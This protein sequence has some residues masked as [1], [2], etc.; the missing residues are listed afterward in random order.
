MEQKKFALILKSPIHDT[1]I[2][3]MASWRLTPSKI[4][5]KALAAIVGFS[6]SPPAPDP[7]RQ[8]FLTAI[9]KQFGRMTEILYKKQEGD[10]AGSRA[11]K[12]V[13][14]ISSSELLL[15]GLETLLALPV[16]ERKHFT[17]IFTGSIGLQI[18]TE[19]PVV[20]WVQRTPGF[21][22]SLVRFYRHPEL[23]VCVGEMLRVCVRHE[24]LATQ[25]RTPERLDELFSHFTDPHFD[26]AADSFATFR[27]LILNSPGAD[28]YLEKNMPQIIARLHGTLVE[29]N[30]AA[31]RQSL[32]L[33]GELVISFR[34]FEQKYLS[35]E[36]N[37]IVMMKLMVS[38]YKN[39]SMEAFHVFKLF[40]ASQEK[41]EPIVKILTLNA[42]KLILFI[43]ELL[44]GIEDE[45]TQG[46]Q[47]FLIAQ[48]EALRPASES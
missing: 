7:K 22:D 32:K 23:A 21:L 26:V 28:A 19:Y 18:G 31:C 13:S 12:L 24:S 20:L 11:L 33:I 5:S 27:E 40:F 14:A 9:A 1:V 44:S 47:Q 3:P 34:S 2:V 36:K 43:G 10:E 35:D 30:Y 6:S 25:L 38:G 42:E 16:D 46:E 29:S 41:P 37:L 39:I 4:V 17:N 15:R 48:L 45:E 8:Q